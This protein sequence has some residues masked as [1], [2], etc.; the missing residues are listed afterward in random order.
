MSSTIATSTIPNPIY[1]QKSDSCQISIPDYSV[2]REQNIKQINDYY[3]KLLDTYTKNYSDYSSQSISND[4]DKR[5]AANSLLKPQVIN[6]NTQII[7]LSQSLINNVNQDTDLITDQKNQ[8][9]IKMSSIDTLMTNIKM[10]TDKD[11]EMTVLSGSRLDSLSST[12][13]GSED[14]QFNTYVYIGI[15]IL[16]VLVIIGLIVYLV[17]TGYTKSG[18]LQSTSSNS[19]SNSLSNSPIKSPEIIS[20]TKNIK[21]A[22]K[23]NTSSENNTSTKM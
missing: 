10:L 13:T 23:T 20:I 19:L 22:N 15:C 14:M 11:N 3:T 1:T 4:A 2:L 18:P 7:N 5:Q 6:Y 8:L 17:Y 16:L 9:S 12:K 21:N